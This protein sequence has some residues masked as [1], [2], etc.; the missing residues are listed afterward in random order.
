MKIQTVA[1]AQTTREVDFSSKIAIVIDVLRAT[2]VMTTAL[3]NGAKAVIPAA[4]IEE[5]KTIFEQR[6]D[7]NTLLAG[8]RNAVKIEGFHLGNS[9]LEY[10][11]EKVKDKTIIQTTT[12]GTVAINAVSA[13]KQVLAG[14]FLNAVAVAD[15]VSYQPYD[16]VIVCAG[17]NGFFSL[18]DALCAGML[19]KLINDRT[20]IESDDLGKLLNHFFVSE[21]GNIAQKLAGCKHLQYLY[22]KGF[23]ADIEYC[24]QPGLLATVPILQNGEMILKS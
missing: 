20:G 12:N 7:K 10:I 4:S 24:L 1:T 18:D 17:T 15:Y 2:S 5:A 22:S 11:T 3:N 13:A 19:I 14:C 6:A 21:T 8:E 16:L 23:R 9:P